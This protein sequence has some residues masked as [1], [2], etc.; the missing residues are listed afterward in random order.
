MINT[1]QTFLTYIKA[2]TTLVKTKSGRF[3]DQLEINDAQ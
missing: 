1:S 2:E 3:L